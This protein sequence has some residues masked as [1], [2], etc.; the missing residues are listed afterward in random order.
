VS[1]TRAGGFWQGFD[2]ATS[3][4]PR[5][6]SRR[7]LVQRTPPDATNRGLRLQN[8]RFSALKAQQ[9]NAFRTAT[10]TACGSTPSCGTP[11]TPRRIRN[12]PQ[13]AGG[14]RVRRWRR[15]EARPLVDLSVFHPAELS[16]FGPA[17]TPCNPW[18][19]VRAMRSRPPSRHDADGEGVLGSTQGGRLKRERPDSGA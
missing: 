19:T 13:A 6:L 9:V 15:T 16:D 2:G 17:L 4:A 5:H 7:Q 1:R 11:S 8:T 12:L 14:A 10:A 3:G 18:M